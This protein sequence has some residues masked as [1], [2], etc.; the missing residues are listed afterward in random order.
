MFFPLAV[1]FG[2]LNG[3]KEPPPMLAQLNLYGF[4]LITLVTNY[5]LAKILF[6]RIYNP[7]RMKITNKKAAR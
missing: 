3:F 4:I 5:F 7:I 6:N 1:V 2:A